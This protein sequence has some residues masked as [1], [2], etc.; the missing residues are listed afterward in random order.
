M[1]KIIIITL[2]I[3]SFKAISQN[4]FLSNG[5]T[6]NHSEGSISYSIGQLNQNHVQ[7]SSFFISEGV[8]QPLE[9][10]DVL[11]ITS[12][13][14]TTTFS[15]YPNPTSD[16]VAIQFDQ[17]FSNDIHIV[18][19]DIAGRILVSEELNVNSTTLSIG[20]LPTA[21]Y[22]LTITTPQQSSTFTL[23]KN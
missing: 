23:I 7:N 11:G 22:Y 14:P 13:K 20:H 1:R 18:I 17:V 19:K 3:G 9:I 21:I 16:I 15:I 12:M 8:Q 10:I 6:I 2:F 4:S 5:N